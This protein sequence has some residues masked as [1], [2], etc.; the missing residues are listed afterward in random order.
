[1]QYRLHVKKILIVFVVDCR[2]RNLDKLTL[3]WLFERNCSFSGCEDVAAEEADL[4][5]VS[6]VDFCF[7]CFLFR[8]PWARHLYWKWNEQI[9]WKMRLTSHTLGFSGYGNILLSISKNISWSIADYI[10]EVSFNFW[11]ECAGCDMSEISF[12]SVVIYH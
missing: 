3:N 10:T 4:R 6:V 7:F 5:F 1:M 2:R 8:F 11:M 9:Y 12:R